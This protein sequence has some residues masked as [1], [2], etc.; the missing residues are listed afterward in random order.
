MVDEKIIKR[1][2]ELKAPNPDF[3]T[4]K[5]VD[6]FLELIGKMELVGNPDYLPYLLEFLDDECYIDG[7]NE[8]LLNNI[9]GFDANYLVPTLL[10][11]LKDIYGRASN[12]CKYLFWT[13]FNDPECLDVLKKSIHLADK[14]TLLKLLDI[15]CENKYSL[16]EHRIIVSELRDILESAK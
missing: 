11:S 12:Q 15:I 4:Q 9:E 7:V 2:R 3:E 6:E 8:T 13:I 10:K 1:M 14:K 5:D 16:P